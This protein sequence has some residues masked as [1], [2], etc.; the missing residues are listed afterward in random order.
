MLKKIDVVQVPDLR[1]FSN[2]AEALV[3]LT[4]HCRQTAELVMHLN[5]EVLQLRQR[6]EALERR[7]R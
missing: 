4:E 3:A 5:N 7:P 2:P 1:K 6:L